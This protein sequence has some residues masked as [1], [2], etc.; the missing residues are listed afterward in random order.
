[1]QIVL[2]RHGRP[3]VEP[4]D[5]IWPNLV[6]FAREYNRAGID[7]ALPPP[8]RVRALA[9][10]SA[11]VL[12]SNLPRAIDSLRM[13]APGRE[14]PAERVYREAGFPPLPS[15]LVALNPPLWATLRI[16]KGLGWLPDGSEVAESLAKARGRARA[17]SGRLIGL[18][19]THGSVLLV[20][21]GMFNTLIAAELN[22]AGWSGPR[23][24]TG[25]YWSAATYRR[26]IREPADD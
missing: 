6:A 10:R 25:S 15:L 8:R 13:L 2:V 14:G 3:D 21:H 18:A 5:R 7:P 12:S 24:P 1:M 4:N 11:F 17:A 26:S 20:G 9:D 23:W 16:A 19:E 22:A